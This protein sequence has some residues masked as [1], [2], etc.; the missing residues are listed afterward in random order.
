MSLFS[1]CNPA[2][3][4]R[5]TP[6]QSSKEAAPLWNHFPLLR[7]FFLLVWQSTSRKKRLQTR[8]C[9]GGKGTTG[10]LVDLASDYIALVAWPALSCLE[11]AT[12]CGKTSHT[13]TNTSC[14]SIKSKL[15]SLQMFETLGE[16]SV[17]LN[18]RV[19]ARRCRVP[20]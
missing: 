6:F 19:L 2:P 11:Y 20:G 9:L 5:V 14:L 8:H 12:L 3:A 17:G 10:P 16:V 18:R 7:E 4:P 13:I 1:H 15:T